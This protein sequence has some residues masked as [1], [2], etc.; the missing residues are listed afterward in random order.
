[1]SPVRIGVLG[2]G[3]I[4]RMHAEL[5]ARQV[6]GAEVA[7]V[8]DVVGEAS[9]ALAEDL[10]VRQAAEPAEILEAGDVDAVAICT[11]THTHIDLLVA[12]AEA[13]KAAFVEKPWL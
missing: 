6:P 13:G 7:A 9:A 5:I 11:S 12:T 4:G 1:M 8:Y 2:C 3:R 10:G